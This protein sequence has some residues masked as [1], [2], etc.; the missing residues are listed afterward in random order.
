MRTF[1]LSFHMN[2]TPDAQC[3]VAAYPTL[4]KA[5]EAADVLVAALGPQCVPRIEYPD[6]P[7]GQTPDLL[8]S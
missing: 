8:T 3:T 7:E 1:R 6:E 5:M 4:K 2:A